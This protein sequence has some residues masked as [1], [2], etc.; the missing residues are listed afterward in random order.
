MTSRLKL[1]AESSIWMVEKDIIFYLQTIN[2][3]HST[4]IMQVYTQ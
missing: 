4:L 1:A 3:S 2:V